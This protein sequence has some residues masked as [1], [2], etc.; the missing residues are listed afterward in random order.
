MSGSYNSCCYINL[1]TP[2]VL[3]GHIFWLLLHRDYTTKNVFQILDGSAT[4]KILGGYQAVTRGE[5]K[6]LQMQMSPKPKYHQNKNVIKGKCHQNTN[7]SKTPMSP[8]IKMSSKP[9]CHQ[10][11]NVIRMQLSPS[12]I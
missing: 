5:S 8:K 7:V 2:A 9:K 10:N 1:E 4:K 6:L 11:S 12:S 3:N